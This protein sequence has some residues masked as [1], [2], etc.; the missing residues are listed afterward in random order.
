M[1]SKNEKNLVERT[2]EVVDLGYNP[3]LRGEHEVVIRAIDREET[4]Q[5]RVSYTVVV[6]TALGIRV[7]GRVWPGEL[8]ESLLCAVGIDPLE[9]GQ[10]IPKDKIR[11]KKVQV[12]LGRMSGGDT[13]RPCWVFKKFAPLA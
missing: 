9:T 5:G 3:D 13:R 4:D 11:G 8:V 12:T 2:D 1:V 7:R 10:K 6:E